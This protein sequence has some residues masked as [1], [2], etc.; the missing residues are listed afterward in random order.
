MSKDKLERLKQILIEM[1]SV[2]VAY[3]GGTDSSLLCK[4][5]RDVLGGRALAVTAVSP[6]MPA[7]ERAEAEAIA[8]AIGARHVLMESHEIQDPRY[9]A[10]TPQR[11][12]FCKSSV[13][14]QLSEYAQC[15]G[16]R[17]VI[18]GNN[19]DDLDDY[20]PGR[21]AAKE[22][23]I[24]SPL[25]EA[26]LTKSDIRQL[27]RELG[28]PNWNKPSS[29]CL[30]SRIP[31][32]SPVT[33]QA[34][35]QIERAELVLR[36]MG[37]SQLRVRHHDQLARIEVEPADLQRVLAAREQIVRQF[38]ALGYTFVTLDLAGF[39]SGSMNEALSSPNPP[40]D[41]R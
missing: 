36:Q 9:T 13:F 10:N 3:S 22:L 21:Q 7:R 24:R 28:L 16:Y 35:E 37:L 18:D 31:Y 11:C 25:Q 27:A 6:T 19:V 33:M 38:K 15:E 34:L 5:A 40:L 8:R 26:G 2:V 1:E 4:V 20:R 30:A 14:G 17:Y 23:G 32:G 29:A 39:R 12:Y 41:S